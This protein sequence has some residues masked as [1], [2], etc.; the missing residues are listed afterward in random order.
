MKPYEIIG[1][2]QRFDRANGAFARSH[3]DPD[4]QHCAADE[5]MPS[6]RPTYRREDHALAAASRAA[7]RILRPALG[8]FLPPADDVQSEPIDP[9]EL[10]DRVK[11]AAATLGAAEVGVA[12]VNP[13]W[14]YADDGQGPSPVLSEQL[15]VAVVMTIEMDYDLIATSPAPG[16]SAATGLAYSQ[17]SATALSLA[18]YLAAQGYKALPSGN[19]TALS[20]PLAI[21]AGLG[22]CGRNGGLITRRYGPRVRICKVFTDAPLATDAP[23]MFGVRETCLTC[24]KCAEA[25]PAE[26]I[27]T[28]EPTTVGPTPSSNPGV[29]KWYINADRCL[30]FWSANGTNCSNCIRSCPYNRPPRGA[31]AAAQQE[32]RCGG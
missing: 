20:I 10:T 19:D 31:S 30:S 25:C 3:S 18:T 14:L 24:G 6:A 32:G 21:D 7:D 22:E 13:L 29:R 2:L 27:S 12:K 17:M 28:G 4:F 26:A 1:D 16:A 15:N 23:V 5:D 11:Q 9:A 8:H